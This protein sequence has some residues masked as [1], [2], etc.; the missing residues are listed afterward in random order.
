MNKKNRILLAK[1]LGYIHSDGCFVNRGNNIFKVQ[2]DND[3][4]TLIK[5]FSDSFQR[6][7]LVKPHIHS[8]FKNDKKHFFVGKQDQ[9]IIKIMRLFDIF[10]F[11]KKEKCAYLSGLYDGDGSVSFGFKKD[12]QM[13]FRIRF[14]NKDAKLIETVKKFLQD[15]GIKNS[16][17]Y[18]E[19]IRGY[20]SGIFY[21]ISITNQKDAKIFYEN[22][23]LKSKHK[24]VALK[25]YLKIIKP[26]SSDKYSFKLK[27]KAIKLH[28]QGFG[29]R[30]IAKILNVSSVRVTRWYKQFGDTKRYKGY[31]ARWDV[32]K[33]KVLFFKK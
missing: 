26:Y 5:D 27:E 22:I 29:C 32:V 25:N 17:I 18:S 2:F 10:S 20:G 7:F 33:E 1:L 28:K 9:K 12:G 30:K 13:S 24:M 15:I 31:P 4:F 14:H 6:V 16:K 23:K 19:K 11:N 8:Y 21:N 3:D